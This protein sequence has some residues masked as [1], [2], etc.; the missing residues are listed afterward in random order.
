MD[1]LD[2]DPL[3]ISATSYIKSYMSNYD[4]SHSFDHIERVVRLARYILSKSPSEPVLDARVVVLSSLLHDVGD[5]KYLK[6]GEDAT[7]MIAEVLRGLGAPDEL[8]EKVQTICLGVSYSTEVKDPERI[9][10]L[11]SEHPELAVVQDADRIDAIGAVGLGRMFTYGGA[12]TGRSLGDSMQHLDDKLLR[13]E[14]MVK[15]DAGRQLAK[16]RTDRLRLFKQWWVEETGFLR[17]AEGK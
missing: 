10:A 17:G 12:K 5:R 4:A 14:G 11:I 1:Y 9:R 2:D 16:D 15:T 13:L 7:T 3:V 8:A 6:A